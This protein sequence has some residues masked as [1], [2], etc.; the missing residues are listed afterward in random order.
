MKDMKDERDERDRKSV[1]LPPDVHRAA[2]VAAAR[3][4]ISLRELVV[5]LI[6]EAL[7]LKG[8]QGGHD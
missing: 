4:G 7:A 3:A 6:T 1:T 5:K 8:G 2:K